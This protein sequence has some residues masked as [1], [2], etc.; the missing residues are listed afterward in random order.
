MGVL[1]VQVYGSGNEAYR[2]LITIVYSFN[3]K[4]IGN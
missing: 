3:V 1:T 4:E 2:I